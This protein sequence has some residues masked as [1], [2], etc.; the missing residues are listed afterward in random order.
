MVWTNLVRSTLPNEPTSRWRGRRRRRQRRQ[1]RRYQSQSPGS[2]PGPWSQ[3]PRDPMMI[4][5]MTMARWRWRG[6]IEPTCRPLRCAGDLKMCVLC[7]AVSPSIKPND[8]CL[9]KWIMPSNINSSWTNLLI[10]QYNARATSSACQG[11]SY[12]FR[13][14]RYMGELPVKGKLSLILKKNRLKIILVWYYY[15]NLTVKDWSGFKCFC[16]R[17]SFLFCWIKNIIDSLF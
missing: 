11:T 12:N 7:C 6:H 9:R 15:Y 10:K 8:L 17:L 16:F 2:V 14:K 1:R 13:L 5:I 3:V 4:I